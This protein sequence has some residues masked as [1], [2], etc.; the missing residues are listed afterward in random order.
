MTIT[1]G[2]LT[3][4]FPNNCEAS[5]YDDWSHYRNQFINKCSINNKAIDFLALEG[6]PQTL[7]L[8]E[9]KDF[10]S[11]TR[12]PEKPPLEHEIAQKVRDTLAGIVSAKFQ[13]NNHDEKNFAA[14]ALGCQSIRVVLHIEQPERTKQI[15]SLPDLR[16]KLKKL[17]KAIDPHVIITTISKQDDVPWTIKESS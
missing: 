12:N 13:A 5:K 8:C 1:E 14:K 16:D 11:T 10:R 15:Y 9:I 2:L 17:L 3:F 7:W 4:E 6:V